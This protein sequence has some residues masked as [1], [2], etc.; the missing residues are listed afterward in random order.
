MKYINVEKSRFTRMM[1]PGNTTLVA[2]T[3]LDISL[4]QC[5]RFLFMKQIFLYVGIYHT[6]KNIDISRGSS[7]KQKFRKDCTIVIATFV[8]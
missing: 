6:C 2:R 8:T 7:Y 3:N 5:C 4:I 1:N